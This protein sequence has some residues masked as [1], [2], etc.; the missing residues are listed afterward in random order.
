MVPVLAEWNGPAMIAWKG[1]GVALLAVWAAFNAKCTD[2]WLITL[3]LGFGALGDVLLD[4]MGLE[5]GAVAFVIGHLLAIWLYARNP[6]ERLTGSQ[7]ALSLLVL[8]LSVLLVWL[9]LRGNAGW[10]HG[11]AYTGFVAGMAAMAWRSSFPRYRT[12]IGA[13]LFVISDLLIFA[14]LGGQV[15]PLV[16]SA[17]IWPLYFAG[18]AL[19]AWGVVTTLADRRARQI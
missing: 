7:Q 4:A 19:I 8:P 2:G 9:M 17:L 12:G 6:R 5:I 15:A 11:A 10:W 18:Q 14:R 3:V 1:A 13:M 16:A